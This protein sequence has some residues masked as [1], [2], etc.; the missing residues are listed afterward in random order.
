[1]VWR[2]SGKNYNE[3]LGFDWFVMNDIRPTLKKTKKK[4]W[5]RAKKWKTSEWRE[6]LN[7]TRKIWLM[8]WH[9]TCSSREKIGRENE[10]F[11]TLINKFPASESDRHTQATTW[12]LLVYLITLSIA[13]RSHETHETNGAQKKWAATKKWLNNRPKVNGASS[14]SFLV[15]SFH[16]SDELS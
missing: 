3:C 9:V 1:M 10:K 4:E 14:E 5:Q 11:I 6:M 15:I 7:E 13:K 16:L 8:I 2:A 12:K